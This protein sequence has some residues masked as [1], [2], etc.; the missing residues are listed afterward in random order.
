MLAGVPDWVPSYRLSP[1]HT[2]IDGQSLPWG[3]CITLASKGQEFH[4]HRAPSYQRP[5]GL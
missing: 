2:R 5:C 1:P 3:E 4:L